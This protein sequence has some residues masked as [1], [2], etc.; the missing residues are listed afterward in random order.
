M[1]LLQGAFLT[2]STK[3]VA[4]AA[5]WFRHPPR[6]GNFSL[7][8]GGCLCYKTLTAPQLLPHTTCCGSLS[9]FPPAAIYHHHFGGETPA[10]AA[11]SQQNV[12]GGGQI[13]LSKHS[14][15]PPSSVC[16]ILHTVVCMYK[17]TFGGE[18]GPGIF[19]HTNY[20]KDEVF[21]D[22]RRLAS[23][24]SPVLR[25]NWLLIKLSVLGPLC[26][27]KKGASILLEKTHKGRQK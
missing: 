7:R 24:S 23:Y 14:R 26:M 13:V 3:V 5:W 2:L 21:F 16:H 25:A 10:A 8:R 17:V 20:D 27:R 15:A 22:S 4:A 12:A 18:T 9:T 1:K 6:S 11:T 19:S